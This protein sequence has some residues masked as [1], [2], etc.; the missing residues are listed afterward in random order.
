MRLEENWEDVF[1][2][3]ASLRKE[4]SRIQEEEVNNCRCCFEFRRLRTRT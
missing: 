3:E 2:M 1:Y 4:L